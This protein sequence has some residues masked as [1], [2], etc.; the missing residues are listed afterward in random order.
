MFIRD[1]FNR[2]IHTEHETKLS[3]DVVEFVKITVPEHLG[4]LQ[5]LPFINVRIILTGDSLPPGLHGEMIE[6][7]HDSHKRSADVEFQ[8]EFYLSLVFAAF[9]SFFG[10]LMIS[11]GTYVRLE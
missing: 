1:L 4:V 9:L 11:K 3:L 2:I 8:H 7:L 5:S 10:V 6:L